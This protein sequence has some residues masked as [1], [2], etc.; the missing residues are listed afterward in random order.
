MCNPPKFV[1]QHILNHPNVSG[2]RQGWFRENAR[3]DLDIKTGAV[4]A[5]I[6]AALGVIC[7]SG[8][9]GLGRH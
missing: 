9:V 1:S 7:S 8:S 4:W 5:G 6:E 3:L 2:A